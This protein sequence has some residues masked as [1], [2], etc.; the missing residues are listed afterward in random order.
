MATTFSAVW[1][2]V[3][4]HVPD[5]PAMLVR[6]WV[7]DAYNFAFDYRPWAFTLVPRQIVWQDAR[8]LA[9]TTTTGSVQVTSAGL[10]LPAD[11]GRQFRVG[12]F[13]IYTVQTYIDANTIELDQTF[14]SAGGDGAVTATI[15]D[16]W[17]TLPSEFRMFTALVDQVSQRW[18][19]WWMTLEELDL[20][21]PTRTAS[22]D[23]RVLA[24]QGL[25][26][27]PATLGQNQYAFWPI[28]ESAGSLQA[29]L[30]IGPT[31]LA[32][33]DVFKGVFANRDDLLTAGALA[34][35]AQWP[36]TA[37]RPNPYFNLALARSQQEEYMQL[38]QQ[39]D[40]RDDDQNPYS[41]DKIPWQRWTSY[42]WAYSTQLLQ[43]TDATLGAYAGLE[44]WYPMSS[45]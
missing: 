14:Q 36:G 20:L 11:A 25:S 31:A 28:P 15:L 43:Q 41:L 40:L 39:L 4:L 23:P 42:R 24:S 22:G 18:I 1:R 12:T 32:D 19:P 2:L 34:R 37:T 27:F 33:E 26:Q 6:S 45:W 35:A 3:R 13:P 10:F 29:Y 9:V 44:G 38:L 7:Q 30:R 17:T 8:D 5:A 21:D 16:A